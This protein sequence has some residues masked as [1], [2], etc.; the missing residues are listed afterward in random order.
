MTMDSNI[1]T[2]PG[3][4]PNRGKTTYRTEGPK[5]VPGGP[6]MHTL[7]FRSY[8]LIVESEEADLVRDVCFDI[9]K[10][11]THARRLRR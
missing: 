7:L 9:E 6:S 4:S 10:V 5:R 11:A 1:V 2:F 3:S 8:H